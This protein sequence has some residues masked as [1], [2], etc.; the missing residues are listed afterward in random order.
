VAGM[1][2]SDQCHQPEPVGASGSY[3]VTTKLFV[4]SGAPLQLNCGERLPPSG[5]QPPLAAKHP[6]VSFWYADQS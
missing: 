3:A 6:N 4:P 2:T 1:F 5:S